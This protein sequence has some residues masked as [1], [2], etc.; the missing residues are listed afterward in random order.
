MA[1]APIWPGRKAE[2][3]AETGASS[4]APRGPATGSCT[5]SAPPGR[6]TRQASARAA[7][8]PSAPST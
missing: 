2:S 8:P 4:S 7:S 5:A 6:N 3:S 1:V